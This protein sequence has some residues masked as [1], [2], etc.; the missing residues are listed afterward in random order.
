MTLT[1]DSSNFIAIGS[2]VVIFLQCFLINYIFFKKM[3][4]FNWFSVFGSVV[5]II[6]VLC[7]NIEANDFI[8]RTVIEFVVTVILFGITVGGKLKEK[9]FL[10]LKVYFTIVCLSY[11]VQMLICI[12]GDIDSGSL[13]DGD[14]LI[15]YS[16]LLVILLV[17]ALVKKYK[18]ARLEEKVK[19]KIIRIFIYFAMCIMGISIPLTITGLSYASP[20]VSNT[21]FSDF[22]NV[23]S[24]F[25]F[26]SMIF[27]VLF[28]FYINDTNKK[29]KNSFETE[30]MLMEI[31]K[32]YYE[33]MLKKEEGT[34]RFRHDF[35]NY[36]ICLKGMAEKDDKQMM[37]DYIEQLEHRVQDLKPTYYT[38]GN[39][40]MD[41]LINGLIPQIKDAKVVVKGTC[42]EEIEMDSI[43]L[44]TIV[45][46]L[47]Q[48][49]VEEL[50]SFNQN[51][52]SKYFKL[53]ISQGKTNMKLE[54][55][56]TSREKVG[57][58]SSGLPQTSKQNKKDHG[59]G[60]KNVKE[61]VEKNHGT[62]SWKYEEE[63][64]KVEVILP[65]RKK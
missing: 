40:V 36:L 10:P 3:C 52:H 63:E 13:S 55:S 27:L 17:L 60:L 11:M 46:N 59:I 8:P 50:N 21:K 30:K 28:V 16:I 49:A 42:K 23:L 41:I 25:A 43:E 44:C 20:Y 45:S 57:D 64:F 58:K 56:N 35:I 48:N 38:V 53:N 61:T 31:Q 18:L 2:F 47:I 32:N 12:M 33:E 4:K 9:I 29:I 65:L 5:Y 34:R 24:F 54:I 37:M 14:W 19:N 22:T 39:D 62:F 51:Q 7:T 1:I 26:S 15:S 6:L